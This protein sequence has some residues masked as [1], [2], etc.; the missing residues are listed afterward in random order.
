MTKALRAKTTSGKEDDM[1]GLNRMIVLS[2]ALH[3]LFISALILSPSLPTK[4]WTFG[5]VYTVALV[6]LPAGYLEKKPTTSIS[7]ELTTMGVKEHSAVLK[8]STESLSI[9]PIKR[10]VPVK[11]DTSREVEKA[12]EGVRKKME[13]SATSQTKASEQGGVET[14]REIT[15]YYETLWTRIKSEWALPRGILPSEKLEAIVDVTVSRSGI[16]NSLKIEKTSGNRYFDQSAIRAI[17]K[18]SPF[19]PIPENIRGSNLEL[20]I[21]FHSEQLR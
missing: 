16:V 1:A 18:A 15:A 9:P 7:K 10:L 20:G 13:A 8:K 12:I 4:K 6:S 5:P 19:P 3:L 2:L 17:R 21:R 14:N 11:K